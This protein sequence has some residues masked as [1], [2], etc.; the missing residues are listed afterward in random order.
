[1][2]K[3]NISRPTLREW[4]NTGKISRPER[5]WR[6]WQQWTVRH[7]EEIDEVL[8]Q[9]IELQQQEIVKTHFEIQNRR[10]LGAKTKLLP[11]IKGIID[12]EIGDW[13]TF[14]DLFGG[15]GVVGSHFNKEGKRLVINDLLYTNYF[16]YQTFL[17]S[18]AFNQ[19]A[20]KDAIAYL[21]DITVNNENYF[22]QHYGETFF[23]KEN[24]MKIGAIR[25]EI[26]KMR[27]E[28][29]ARE[30]Y[31]LITSLIYA[32]DKVANTFGHYE[33]FRKK[34]DMFNPVRL[35]EP[36]IV[37]NEVNRLNEIYRSD[38]NELVKNIDTDILYIDTPYNSRQYVDAYHLL[39][40]L[41][42]WEKPEVTGV[43]KKMAGRLY[44]KSKYCT[45]S[46]PEVFD[47]LIKNVKAKWIIVSYSNMSQKGDGRSNAKISDDEIVA[48]LEKRGQTT[49]FSQEFKQFTTGIS[50]IDDLQE[51]LFLCRVKG[52]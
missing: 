52:E 5:D 45:K 18:G 50:N 10:Y 39:E 23:S 2:D 15:T 48:S 46:A 16:S 28:F 43:A 6:G 51:R 9:K 3:Y 30:R 35:L 22:S 32:T 47:E 49:S 17:S 8:K 24:A 7:I 36:I 33:A 27:S 31:I 42:K 13:N 34:L 14:T 37:E 19:H 29:N 41:A 1:M 20:I 26:E 38:S 40:N 25:E 44:G 4:M 11:F 12:N 21:N